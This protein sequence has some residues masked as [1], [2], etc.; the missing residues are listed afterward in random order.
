MKNR[1]AIGKRSCLL[2]MTELELRISFVQSTI[3]LSSNCRLY[4]LVLCFSVILVSLG[5][6]FDLAEVISFSK[7]EF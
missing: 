4:H 6:I 3:S 2:I 7:L 5:K 1:I